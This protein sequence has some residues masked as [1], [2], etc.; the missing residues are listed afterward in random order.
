[1]AYISFIVRNY[2]VWLKVKKKMLFN[3]IEPLSKLTDEHD[4][5]RHFYGNEPRVYK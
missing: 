5:H 2:N 1:M 3:I 4:F